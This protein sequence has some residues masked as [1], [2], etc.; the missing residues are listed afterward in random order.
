MFCF[1]TRHGYASVFWFNVKKK[2]V[3]KTLQSHLVLCQNTAPIFL[4]HE[5]QY[6]DKIFDGRLGSTTKLS[7]VMHIQNNTIISEV[8]GKSTQG[9]SHIKT[10]NIRFKYSHRKF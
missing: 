8:I 9:I 6:A 5:H 3:K 7:R 2:Y 1:V 4:H 10:S